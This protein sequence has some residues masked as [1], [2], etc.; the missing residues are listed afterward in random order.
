MGHLLCS[1]PKLSKAPVLQDCF[2]YFQYSLH[3]MIF[4]LVDLFCPSYIIVGCHNSAVV[5]MMRI[6]SVVICLCCYFSPGCHLTTIIY[7]PDP[8]QQA[9]MKISQGVMDYSQQYSWRLLSGLCC[10]VLTNIFVEPV[11][12]L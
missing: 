7:C 1:S 4:Y 12:N 11:E 6:I 10:S 3:F 5:R 8:A 9:L 2:D